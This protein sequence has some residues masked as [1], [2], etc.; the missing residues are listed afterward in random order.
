MI[1]PAP[2]QHAGQNDSPARPQA[3]QNWRRSPWTTLRIWP[4][5]NAAGSRFQ[6]HV[7]SPGLP[8]THPSG[9]NDAVH[10]FDRLQHAIKMDRIL[11]LDDEIELRLL[12]FAC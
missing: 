11:D 5:E 12:I 3:R 8:R 6:Q 9:R 1:V 2:I 4:T 10:A 7:S